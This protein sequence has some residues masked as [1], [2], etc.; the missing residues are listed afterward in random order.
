MRLRPPGWPQLLGLLGVVWLAVGCQADQGE[1][2]E[3]AGQDPDASAFEPTFT[4]DEG[5]FGLEPDGVESAESG[6]LECGMVEVPLDHDDPDGDT[7]ELATVVF[8]GSDPETDASPVLLLGG[9]PGEALVELAVTNQLVRDFYDAGPDLVVVDQRGVGSSDPALT[10]PEVPDLEAQQTADEDLDVLFEALA[11]CREQLV[12]EGIDLDAFHDLANARDVALIRRA[13]GHEQLNL[14]GGSYGTQVA[15][16]AAEDDPDGVRSLILSSP[17]DP[18]ENWVEGSAAGL[19]GALDAVVEA[20]AQDTTCSDEV[21]DLDAALSETA[22]RLEDDP[23]EVTV[24]TPQGEEVTSVY[25]PS[26]FIGAV[27]NIF[28]LGDA[29]TLLPALID[30]A[31]DGDLQPLATI[32][33]SLAEQVGDAISTGMQFSMLC[34][35]EAGAFDPEASLERLD[36]DLIAEYW[37]PASP[38]GGGPT[39]EACEI[40]DVEQVYE[41]GEISIDID[42]PALIVTGAF[43]HVTPP[44]LGEQV[45]RALETSH[46]VEVPVAGHGPLEALGVCGQQLVED[47]L[48][49]PDTAPD[50]GCA[51]A[52]PLEWQTE[53]PVGLG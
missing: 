31:R 40:W 36:D 24:T 45:A 33:A 22:E 47:F 51:T 42:V 2:P 43:D 12:D 10:C 16:L 44:R 26:T 11:A 34:S 50:D 23:Q 14:R 21:G 46:L 20:C 49:D 30:R 38:I 35:G 15:L 32:A 4:V 29:V 13:L 39:V 9:G 3:D 1:Q 7:I 8:P 28:Y 17:V 19:D 48:A 41:P 37:F 25:T 6:G 5:C 18:T 27:T 52:T 53:L